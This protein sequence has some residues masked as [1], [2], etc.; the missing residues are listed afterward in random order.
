[1]RARWIERWDGDLKLGERPDPQA[2]EGEVLIEV[3]A[4]GVGL[5]VLNCI[6]G[7][8]GS[9]PSDL[10]RVPGHELVG[11]IVDCGAG[12]QPARAGERVAAYFYLFCGECARCMAGTESL[13]SNL[14][15]FVGVNTDGGYA[16]RVALPA[17][18]A[19]SLGDG[20]HP[21]AATAVPDA[22]ATPI[23]VAR[24]ARIRPADRVAVIAAGGGVGIHMVQ[25]ARLWGGKVVGLEAADDKLAFLT[26]ELGIESVDS[27]N[28]ERVELP[29][30]WAGRADVVIDLLGRQPSLEWS[31]RALD[32]DGRMVVLTT[33]P[34]VTFPA[35][36][37]ELVFSQGSILGSRYAS[38]RDVLTAA[39][40][41]AEERIRPIVSRTVGLE[42]VE[43]VHG[44]LRGGSLIGR[45]ALRIT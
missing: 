15:G 42:E 22:I 3:E 34:E 41:V 38:R 36:P 6:R 33:F 35:S 44:A 5:T 21:V 30:A 24:R 20:L 29:R 26:D 37:R 7:D 12:I 16:E 9:D 31:A 40:L 4:C 32:A 23:H 13:C 39:G 17:R 2:G 19:I 45:G 8:L 43:E 27:T 18:N 1:V 10:P 14:G 11:R 25:V 28:F